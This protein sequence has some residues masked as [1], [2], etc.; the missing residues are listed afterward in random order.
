MP[1]M[2]NLWLLVSLMLCFGKVMVAQVGASV[3]PEALYESG[4]A[5]ARECSPADKQ[6]GKSI[7][8]SDL[9]SVVNCSLYLVGFVQAVQFENSAFTFVMT[10]QKHP[11][12]FCLPAGVENAQMV[13]IVL[14][15]IREHPAEAHEPTPKLVMFVLHQ[16]YPCRK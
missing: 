5:F 7:S 10:G 11:L 12:P 13:R 1:T 15:Y 3:Q 6:L 2:Q 16:S 8:S 14:K 4:D 9:E